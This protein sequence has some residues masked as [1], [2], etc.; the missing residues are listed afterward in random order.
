MRIISGYLKG[1]KLFCAK[2]GKIRPTSDKVRE[3]VFNILSFSVK[4]TCVLDLFAGTGALGIEAFSRGAKKVFFL[5][6]GKD[7][8]KTIKANTAYLPESS[9]RI[10][11]WDIK[12]SL[13]CLKAYPE[14]FDLV[15][16]D[17]PYGKGLLE[18]ALDHL[19][20]SGALKPGAII[21]G[22]HALSEKISVQNHG[23]ILTDQRKYG[24]TL[25]SFFNYDMGD[26]PKT[27]D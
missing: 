10:I 3:A 14:T 24:K 16:L 15:F 19:I 20:D 22:E 9:R 17:P 27:E 21:I 25:V 13:R 6:N 2:G 18:P 4:N 23:L 1:R 8:L 7:A 5:D 12:K 26:S 11:K